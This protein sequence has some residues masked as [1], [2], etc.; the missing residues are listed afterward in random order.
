MPTALPRPSH[1][2]TRCPA[3]SLP[4]AR[5][6]RDCARL[7]THLE[8]ELDATEKQRAVRH[9]WAAYT[10]L[11]LPILVALGAFTFLDVL[12][13]LEARLPVAVSQAPVTRYLIDSSRPGVALLVDAASAVGWG[14]VGH[15]LQLAAGAFLLLSTLVQFLRCRMRGLRTRS[16]LPR[17]TLL[18][19]RSDV[20]ALLRH[21]ETL[22]RAFSWAPKIGEY[23]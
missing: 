17:N 2:P 8:E 21:V 18:A 14:A 22:H 19:L 20:D 1:P 13:S 6:R 10:Y 4:A 7:L 11:L 3:S 9:K 16:G 12:L 15:R 5:C 23:D